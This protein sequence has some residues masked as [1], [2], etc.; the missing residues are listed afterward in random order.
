MLTRI[1]DT[2]KGAGINVYF[3]GQKKGNCTENYAVVYEGVRSQFQSYTTD[4]C[5]Y[6]VAVVVPEDMYSKATK[7]LDEVVKALQ[8]LY[9]SVKRTHS[10]TN[11]L[12]DDM[13]NGWTV[14]EDFTTYKKWERRI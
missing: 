12:W 14:S 10:R 3:A 8:T 6:T 2:L 1:Y 13:A 11:V 4:V 7:Y 5:Y 9:P